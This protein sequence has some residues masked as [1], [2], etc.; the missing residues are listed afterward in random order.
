MARFAAGKGES[1][2]S[3]IFL[4]GQDNALT[5]LQ[6]T[7][8]ESEDILQ[9]LLGD[10][11]A[12]LGLTSGPNDRLLL[13]SRELAVPDEFSGSAR[14][15]L[16]HLFVDQSG[17]PVLVE[18]KRATDTR[19]RREVVAQMLDYGANGSAYWPIE[20]LIEAFTKTTAARA[21]PAAG[22]AD[23]ELA[24]SAADPD[25][26]LRMFLQSGEPEEFWLRVQ[27]NLRAGRVRLVFVADRIPKE[28]R[29]IVEFL[30]E[31]MRP[32][33]V[34]AL[35]LEQ[36]V[37]P[38]GMRTLI[39]RLIGN[40]AQAQAVKT[41]NKKPA[42]TSEYKR[43]TPMSEEEWLIDL[44]GRFGRK[45]V[46]ATRNAIIWFRGKGLKVGITNSQDAVFTQMILANGKSAWPFFLRRSSGK[47]ETSLQYLK[48]ARLFPQ[49]RRG[50]KFLT[51]FDLCLAPTRR[52]QIQVAGL[53]SY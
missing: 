9:Q 3:T 12:V 31:Q 28:L 17:V 47:L 52:R 36:F 10:H 7:P 2:S 20:Q 50:K 29:R 40:T 23:P 46:D 6:Q 14:W 41:V 53:Q 22:E 34:L 35:E 26:E 5:E 15:A 4:V 43:L 16:D 11:P 38:S 51:E 18:V 48:T 42:S 49:R 37:A 25:A 27:T 39:P 33:E 21:M 44:E 1:M 19:S 30:N 8:Y 24:T 45:A 32:A 13:V